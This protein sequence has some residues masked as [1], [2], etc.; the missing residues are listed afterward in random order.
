MITEILSVIYQI[1]NTLYEQVERAKANQ[2]QSKRLSERIVAVMQAV[3][4][5]E[6][7]KDSEQCI[8]VLSALTK[9]S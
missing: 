5:L 6:T 9:C 2:E 4:R 7:V 8:P 3:K 1:S